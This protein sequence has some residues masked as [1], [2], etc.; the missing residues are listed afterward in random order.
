MKIR[1]LGA[2]ALLFPWV[3]PCQTLTGPGLR[4]R[5]NFG[6]IDI[7]LLTAVAPMTAANFLTYANRG[8]FDNSIFHRSVP[9]F[10]FQGGG[11]T[12][13]GGKIVEIPQDPPVIN[14]F[15]VSNTH[16][17]IAMAKLGSDQHGLR[18]AEPDFIEEL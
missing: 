13:K 10:V 5:T 7:V 14:E 4:L 17:T 9:G 6:D 16:G 1:L 2:A 12:F 8:D 15:N 11:F 18:F 3:L